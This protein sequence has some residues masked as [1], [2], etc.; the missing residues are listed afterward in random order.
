VKAALSGVSRA[1]Q[2]RHT[3]KQNRAAGETEQQLPHD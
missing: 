3:Q 1:R 2:S